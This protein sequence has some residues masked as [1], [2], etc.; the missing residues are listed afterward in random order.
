M[1]PLQVAPLYIQ[2]VSL[3]EWLCIESLNDK[4]GEQILNDEPFYSLN[5]SQ[6]GTEGGALPVR[7]DHAPTEFTEVG[8]LMV[9][10]ATLLACE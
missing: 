1:C 9:V 7:L 6:V 10:R 5:G 3:R 4:M 2:P 8:L